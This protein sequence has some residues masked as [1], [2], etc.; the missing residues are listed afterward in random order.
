MK[1]YKT[2]LLGIAV[3]LFGISCKVTTGY[4]AFN[5]TEWLGYILPFIEE[6]LGYIL[7]F[8]GIIITLNGYFSESKKN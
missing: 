1:E 5:L 8:V 2:M 3:I 6:C 4:G 7:P